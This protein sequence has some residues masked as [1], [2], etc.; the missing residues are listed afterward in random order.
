MPQD[1]GGN[2]R[3]L[4]AECLPTMCE[5][6]VQSP[7]QESSKQKRNKTNKSPTTTDKIQPFSEIVSLKRHK[8]RM[9]PPESLL[10]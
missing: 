10:T 6:Q 9:R 1:I 5:F 8:I 7:A 3:F 2:L 4:E